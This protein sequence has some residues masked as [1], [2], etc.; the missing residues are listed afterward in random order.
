MTNQLYLAAN[1]IG[2]SPYFGHLQL[3]FGD[4]LEAGQEIE[5]Q[6]PTD[7]WLLGAIFSINPIALYT[8]GNWDF[9]NP[10]PNEPRTHIGGGHTPFF[11]ENGYYASVELT[12]DGDPAFG[13]DRTADDIWSIWQQTHLQ[14]SEQ[15]DIHYGLLQNS[16]S[17]ASTLL[18]LTGFDVADWVGQATPSEVSW[19]PGIGLD[20]L[21]D[22]DFAIDLRLAGSEHG[23][24][25]W[26]GAGDDHISGGAGDDMLG[27]G[28]GADVVE[29][30]AGDDLIFLGVWDENGDLADDGD[31]DLVI[32]GEGHDTIIGGGADDR[33]VVRVNL[34]GSGPEAAGSAMPATGLGPLAGTLAIPLLGGFYRPGDPNFAYHT[35]VGI[36]V[37]TSMIEDAEMGLSYP[38]YASRPTDIYWNELINASAGYNDTTPIFSITYS[39]FG[40]QLEI[41]LGYWALDAQ[42]GAQ[43]RAHA[44]VTIIDYEEGDFGIQFAPESNW[45]YAVPQSSADYNPLE[46]ASYFADNID[47]ARYINF[48][49]EYIVVPELLTVESVLA[50]TGGSGG[51]TPQST[52]I[53]TLDGGGAYE[54]TG[55]IPESVTGIVLSNSGGTTLTLSLIHI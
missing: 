23:D 53:V 55:S 4:S 9:P 41:D 2:G 50:G 35:A 16:N 26:S 19:F 14:F 29:G 31:A 27:D 34:F 39:L 54:I 52:G 10:D 5:V 18:A 44:S 36:R 11:G 24:I 3:V 51:G 46:P 13:A 48:G 33:L 40:S 25:I 12:W 17:Y 45:P 42:T 47:H 32:V 20:V 22:P 7:Y 6:A 38:V 21:S 30:S 49:G 28:A 15:A 8:F 37:Y 1:Y 43:V